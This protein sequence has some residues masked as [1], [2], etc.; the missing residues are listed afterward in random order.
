[1]QR[2][3]NIGAVQNVAEVAHFRVSDLSLEHRPFEIFS[4]RKIPGTHDIPRQ[5]KPTEENPALAG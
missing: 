4:D 5:R 3:R 2:Q 1:M